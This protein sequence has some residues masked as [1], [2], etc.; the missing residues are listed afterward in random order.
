[1]SLLMVGNLDSGMALLALVVLVPTVSWFVYAQRENFGISNRI[2]QSRSDSY[3]ALAV[4]IGVLGWSV[5]NARFAAQNIYIYRDPAIYTNNGAWLIDNEG[6]EIVA[7]DVFGDDER[8]KG[9]GVSLLGKPSDQTTERLY[10]HGGLMLPAFFGLFGRVVGENAAFILNSFIGGFALLSFFGLSRF[11]V[12][13]K[14]AAFGTLALASLLPMIYFSRDNYTEPLSILFIFSALSLTHLAFRSKNIW[15]WLLAGLS[16]GATTLTRIDAYLTVAG[17]LLGFVIWLSISPKAKEKR[18]Q[19]KNY[20]GYLGA[21]ATVSLLGWQA[22]TQL[23]AR[24]Y[25]DLRKAFVQ[26]IM[27]IAAIVV[28]GVVLVLISSHKQLL[29]YA[30]IKTKAWRW[31]LALVATLIS[32]V[33]IAS[34]PLWMVGYWSR[35]NPLVSLLLEQEGQ[36]V[37]PRSFGE[38]SFDWIWWYIGPVFALIA[39]VGYLYLVRRLLLQKKYAHYVMLLSVFTVTFLVYVIRPSVTPDQIWA[40]RRYLPVVFPSF[41]LF[42][43]VGFQYISDRFVHKCRLLAMS[44]PLAIA[45]AGPLFISQPF[46]LTKTYEHEYAHV[47]TVCDVLPENAAVLLLGSNS[48][49][50]MQAVKTYCDVPAERSPEQT[51]KQLSVAAKAARQN[52]YEPYVFI[53]GNDLKYLP[54]GN[55]KLTLVNAGAFTDL[56]HSLSHPPRTVEVNI[57]QIYMGKITDTGVLTEL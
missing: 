44:W 1:M 27:L 43:V 25:S 52:G 19:L 23:G 14:W 13:S 31:P 34:R 47:Q 55:D 46:L 15:L 51:T 4:I 32:A 53:H 41:M 29:L 33:Y 30:D 40:S 49:N 18:I 56:T 26:Q 9:D 2:A 16:V 5:F 38:H 3:I 57:R 24:Y 11:Y 39:L 10:V 36:P 50:M 48:Y 21:M 42:S 37:E 7:S 17:F 12:R 45:M 35:P 22:Y 8:I 54:E 28:F 20:L 6:I